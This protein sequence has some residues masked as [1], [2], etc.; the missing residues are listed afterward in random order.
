MAKHSYLFNPNLPIIKKNYAGNLLVNNKFVNQTRRRQPHFKDILKWQ[1]TEK[2]QKAEKKND[3]FRVPIKSDNTFFDSKEDCIVWLGH[4]SFFIRINGVSLLTD[5]SLGN[6]ALL[7]R[8]VGLPCDISEIR[9][10]DYILLSHGHR[11]HLDVPSLRKIL[12]QNSQAEFLVPLKTEALLRNVGKYKS[13]QE[14]GWYQ[15]FAIPEKQDLTITFLP[16]KH[17]NRRGL[18]DTNL[19]LWGSFMIETAEKTIYFAGDTAY[20]PHFKEIKQMFEKIDVC[21]M[22][23]GAYKPDFIMRDSHVNPE[24]A[25]QAFNELEAQHF[26]PMHYG[27]YDLSD[28]PIGE[29]IRWLRQLKKDGVLR[30]ELQDLAVGERFYF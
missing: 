24:E 26:L 13:C 8:L 22:P 4:A 5:P 20:A 17:W 9:N 12:K 16:A 28:E 7:K 2:P 23:I 1:F 21:M 29:P 27:T 14:A 3:T 19:T 10:I 25:V 6:V 11:D 30:G 18:T 15:R